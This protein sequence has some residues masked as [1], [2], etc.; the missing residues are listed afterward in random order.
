M[1]L[2]NVAKTFSLEEQR[3]EINEI[4][5]DLDS[6][7][8]TVSNLNL[9][10]ISNWDTAYGWGDHAQAGYLTAYTETDPVFGASEAANITS[11]D[12]T[13]WDTA[14]GWGD[15]SQAGY[16][17]DLSASS[18]NGLSDVSISVPT[19]T[20]GILSFNALTIFCHFSNGYALFGV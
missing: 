11:T 20:K 8:T 12:T 10:N 2:R 13:N 6:L 5:A 7:D 18:I 15:H 17:T 4:A 19:W 14:Y 1:V 9:S 16:L 3:Q